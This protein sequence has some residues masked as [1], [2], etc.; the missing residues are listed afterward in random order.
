MEILLWGAIR[1]CKSSASIEPPLC[2]DGNEMVAKKDTFL[3]VA[4]IEP[5]LC[6]DGNED[7]REYKLTM[8]DELQ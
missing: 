8:H 6:S 4:S 3:V 7:D 1:T 2:S 5:P